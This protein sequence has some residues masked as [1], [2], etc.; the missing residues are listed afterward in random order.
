MGPMSFLELKDISKTYKNAKTKTID[1]LNLSVEKGEIIVILGPSGCGKTTTLKVVAGLEGLDSG[2]VFI[3]GECMND[4]RTEKRPIAMVFQKPLLFRNMTVGQNIDLALRVK[5]K[6]RSEELARKTAELLK[7]VKLEGFENRRSTQLSGGQEQRVSLAR[8]LMTDPKVLLLDE[9]LSA[10]DAELRIE[11]RRII[12]EVCKG[13]GLTVLFVTHD[14][15]EAVAIADRIALFLDGAIIQY[16]TPVEFYRK[17]G[18]VKVARF[19]GWKNFIPAK[20]EGRMVTSPIGAFEITGLQERTGDAVLLVRPE[21]VTVSENGDMVAKVKSVS[22]LGTR[23][24]Y[25]ID[26]CGMDLN[27]T[28]TTRYMYQPGD[29]IRFDLC[30]DMMWAVE[31][32]ASVEVKEVNGPKKKGSPFDWILNSMSKKK[33]P[34]KASD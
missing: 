10:L 4:I 14:Q 30:S 1:G 17:P 26:H 23:S 27:I 12:R 11:M 16:G 24:E 15:Q 8:A 6:Y 7:L 31:P 9:P 5:N 18:S 22:Y 29:E 32:E 28:V 25:V 2:S 19:F 21:A 34:G 13:L 3:D 20:Q 33:A